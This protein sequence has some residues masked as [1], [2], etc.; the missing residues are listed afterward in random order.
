MQA[1]RRS[2][3]NETLAVWVLTSGLPLVFEWPCW[4]VFEGLEWGEEV[5]MFRGMNDKGA[6]ANRIHPQK[7]CFRRPSIRAARA[8][9]ADAQSAIISTTTT[10]TTTD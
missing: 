9:C 5:Q 6:R 8:V 2:D 1:R 7:L 3:N 10:T 4:F